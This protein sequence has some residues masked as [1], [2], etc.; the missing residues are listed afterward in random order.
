[1]KWRPATPED[2]PAILAHHKQREEQLGKKVDFPHDLFAFP[3]IMAS[4]G[5]DEKGEV[6][7][8]LYFE[9]C[10]EAAMISSNPEFVR[11]VMEARSLYQEPLHEKGF[12]LVHAFVPK[13]VDMK[14]AMRLG[15]WVNLDEDFTHYGTLTF[16]VTK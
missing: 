13:E 14:D 10:A 16:E 7:G 6:Q 2:L 4:V 11:H 1:V 9:I 15:G 12:S 3:V 8:C 5:L